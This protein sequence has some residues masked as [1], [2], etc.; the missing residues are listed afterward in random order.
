MAL[1]DAL[2]AGIAIITTI[3]GQGWPDLEKRPHFNQ[4][5]KQQFFERIIFLSRQQG[6]GTIEQIYTNGER[7]YVPL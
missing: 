3:H 7:Q 6:M 1:E 4:L 2:N 5:I